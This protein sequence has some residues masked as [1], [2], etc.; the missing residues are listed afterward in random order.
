MARC[1]SSGSGG[2]WYCAALAAAALLTIGAAIE[3][4]GT[5]SPPPLGLPPPGGNVD[6]RSNDA[7]VALGE[8]LFV[9]PSLSR[10]R[11]VSCSSCHSP[12]KAFADGRARAVGIEGRQLTRNAPSLLNVVYTRHLLWDGRVS[13]LEAQVSIPL[14]NSA[15]M[16]MTEESIVTRVRG[17]SEYESLFERAFGD[18]EVTMERV[19]LALA[20]FERSLLAGDAPFDR[21]WHGRESSMSESAIRG[22]VSF[23]G[24]ARC[25]SC[26]SVRQAYA[27]FTDDEFHNIGAGEDE[28]REDAGRMSA[29]SKEVD[30]GKFKTPTLRNVALTGPYMHDGSIRTLKEVVAFYTRGGRA[31]PNLD[32]A[33]RPIRLSA[34]E[35]EDL[36]NFLEALTS[37]SL[38]PMRDRWGRPTPR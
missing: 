4:D 38:P 11:S 10:D 21:W 13:G 16:D 5:L 31:N 33:I 1:A 22:F 9:D 14:F 20:A 3:G 15:E 12:D 29:T 30:R 17:E 18:K 8:R 2:H 24:R 7:R 6:W 34:R 37:T 26:H 27:L 25:S 23:V 36:V 35:V 19:A 28:G 32:P